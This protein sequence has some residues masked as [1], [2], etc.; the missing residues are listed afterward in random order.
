[1]VVFRMRR[2]VSVS[3]TNR[4]VVQGSGRTDSSSPGRRGVSHSRRHTATDGATASQSTAGR[5]FNPLRPKRGLQAARAGQSSPCYRGQSSWLPKHVG[6]LQG[7]GRSFGRWNRGGHCRHI[8][9]YASRGRSSSAAGL[10]LPAEQRG[11]R[12]DGAC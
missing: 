5:R 4:L 6:D 2:H 12:E 3:I 10:Q 1:M 8:P 11:V 7:E 9:S